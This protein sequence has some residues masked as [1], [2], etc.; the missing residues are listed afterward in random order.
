[1]SNR[2]YALQILPQFQHI[3]DLHLKHLDF[4]P[5]FPRIEL[6]A[7]RPRTDNP[8]R[9]KH[10]TVIQPLFKGYGFV[11]FDVDQDQWLEINKVKGVVKLI[12]K[13]RFPIPVR[14]GFVEALQRQDPIKESQLWDLFDEY[15]PGML[16]EITKEGHLKEHARAEVV[17]IRGKY[18]EITFLLTAMLKNTIWINKQDVTPIHDETASLSPAEALELPVESSFKR[19]KGYAG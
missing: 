9:L 15:F 7:S 8:T 13:H 19:D 3:A 2:W 14:I 6:K 10:H 11:R 17:S 18:L 16:V 4:P 12:P 1:M 5:F